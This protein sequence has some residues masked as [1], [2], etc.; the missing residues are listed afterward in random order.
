MFAMPGARAFALAPK[1]HSG[2]VAFDEEGVFVG[3][4]P[5]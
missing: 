5:Y 4:V 3:G 2:G 1:R